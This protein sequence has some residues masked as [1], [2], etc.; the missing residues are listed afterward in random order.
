M[1]RYVRRELA[2]GAAKSAGLV[3]GVLVA[4]GVHASRRWSVTDVRNAVCA[5]AVFLVVA[6]LVRSTRLG[7]VKDF[8]AAAPLTDAGPAPERGEAGVRTLLAFVVTA[9]FVF[10]WS[11]MWVFVL[12]TATDSLAK[13]AVGARWEHRRGRVLWRVPD[14]TSWR[15]A[16]SPV[17]SR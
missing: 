9:A 2:L 7:H 17:S 16:Y 11:D 14:G 10:L 3:A 1:V 13:A 12:M 6:A 15:P 4:G 5:A 8:E